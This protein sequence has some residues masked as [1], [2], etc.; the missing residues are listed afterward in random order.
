MHSSTVE[1]SVHRVCHAAY[2]GNRTN[3]KFIRIT[4]EKLHTARAV[5]AISEPI[6]LTHSVLQSIDFSLCSIQSI[7][8]QYTR[9]I[10]TCKI[11]IEMTKKLSGNELP[12]SPERNQKRLIND[13]NAYFFSYSFLWKTIECQYFSVLDKN[14]KVFSVER[15]NNQKLM[16]FIYEF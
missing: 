1:K 7:Y 6:K 16:D 8:R 9:Y 15:I 2:S 3:A 13:F 10:I 12:K 11:L 14:I 4:L 5:A